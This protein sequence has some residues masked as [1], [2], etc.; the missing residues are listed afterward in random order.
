MGMDD[1]LYDKCHLYSS[2]EERFT[3]KLEEKEYGKS[4]SKILMSTRKRK[5]DYGHH[6]CVSFLTISHPEA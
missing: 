4:A 6:F 3:F 2:L 5:N 1:D